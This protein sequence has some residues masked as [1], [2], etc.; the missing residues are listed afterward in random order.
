MVAISL[1]ILT[2][3]VERWVAFVNLGKAALWV[4]MALALISMAH[5]IAQ[6]AR[7]FDLGAES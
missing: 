7:R 5:Y 2:V 1:L 6:F 4:V 3:Y